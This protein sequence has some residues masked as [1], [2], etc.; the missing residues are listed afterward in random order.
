MSRE[1]LAELRLLSRGD[2]L[3][4]LRELVR[5]R[6]AELG[7][8][9]G[10]APARLLELAGG[11]E[12]EVRNAARGLL[13]RAR[14]AEV[15][16]RQCRAVDRT[17]EVVRTLVATAR[18]KDG[19]AHLDPGLLFAVASTAHQKL[20]AFDVDGDVVP[21]RRRDLVQFKAVARRLPGV[22]ASVDRTALH[23]R[24]RHGAGGLDLRSR[25]PAREELRDALR[26]VLLAPAVEQ[27]VETVHGRVAGS[28]APL[29]PSPPPP[30]ARPVARPTGAWLGDILAALGLP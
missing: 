4:A 14:A 26:V 12:R 27:P 25:N 15:Q 29:P 28:S 18:W 23:L 7:G 9:A 30:A 8:A 20:I 5:S 16:Q 19:A 10:V 3:P 17:G 6:A 1:A 11:S 2:D 13:E 21:V 22:C 24:W